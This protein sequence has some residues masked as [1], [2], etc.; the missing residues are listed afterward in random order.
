MKTEMDG[1]VGTR[2]R[3]GASR[4]LV[5]KPEGRRQR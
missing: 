1:A 2:D 4:L 5:G 3:R